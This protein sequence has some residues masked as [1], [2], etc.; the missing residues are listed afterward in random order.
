M[1]T[2]YKN[3]TQNLNAK[4]FS[5]ERIDRTKSDFVSYDA[6][7]A[8]LQNNEI[9]KVSKDSKIELHVYSGDTWLTGNHSI[10]LQTIIVA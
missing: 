10:Q 6:N 2:Q 5:A 8:I 3:I 7:Q 1:L 9:L 4:S